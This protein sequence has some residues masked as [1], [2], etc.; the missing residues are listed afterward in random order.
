MVVERFEV[1]DGEGREVLVASPYAPF[2]DRLLEQLREQEGVGRVAAV[3]SAEAAVTLAV[4]ETF[5]A[6]LVDLDGQWVEGLRA[7]ELLRAMCP[8]ATIVALACGVGVE[9]LARCRALGA[10]ALVDKPSGLPRLALLLP[11]RPV[12][13]RRLSAPAPRPATPEG[14]PPPAAAGGAAPGHPPGR[15]PARALPGSPSPSSR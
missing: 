9:A 10:D 12:D 15:H 6:V 4:V 1:G 2:S 13:P 5:D 8:T 11:P 7:I 3:R 14:A